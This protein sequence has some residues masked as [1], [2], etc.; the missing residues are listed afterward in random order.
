MAVSNSDGR[1]LVPP[2]LATGDDVALDVW[3]K[4][5]L[6]AVN[7]AVG[8]VHSRRYTVFNAAGYA[9]DFLS[10][11]ATDYNIRDDTAH[12]F[13]FYQGQ[14][15]Y[16]LSELYLYSTLNQTCTVTLA[17]PN[18]AGTGVGPIL[19]TESANLAA[20]T[21]ALVLT[22]YAGGTGAASTVK[23]VPALAG[24]LNRFILSVTAGTTP[25]S[26]TLSIRL[27]QRT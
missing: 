18:L 17:L 1:I 3:L 10:V 20:T 4:S 26:G 5:R 2:G 22:P 13:G 24:A 11:A 6:D 8:I 27:S 14:S 15:G 7:D 21:G 23:I 12:L 16:G 9:V 19:Y 25:A